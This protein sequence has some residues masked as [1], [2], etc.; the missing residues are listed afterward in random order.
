MTA[1]A[2]Y[3]HMFCCANALLWADGNLSPEEEKRYIA[4]LEA[5]V[6]LSG[7][8]KAYLLTQNKKNTSFEEHWNKVTDK[9]HRAHLINIAHMLFWEDGVFC[10]SEKE[11]FEKMQQL[12]LK[13]V[14]VAALE[15]EIG[16]MAKSALAQLNAEEKARI[17]D[18]MVHTRFFHYVGEWINEQVHRLEN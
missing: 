11:V 6:E 7:E 9:H 14:D 8:Q 12:H 1:T 13:T 17:D 10:H 15:E 4:L 5:N 2:S 18:M 16:Q 3:Y